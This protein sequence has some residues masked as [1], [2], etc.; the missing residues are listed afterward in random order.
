M[1]QPLAMDFEALARH[2]VSRDVH[3]LGGL[4]WGAARRLV[5]AM[6]RLSTRF[7]PPHPSFSPSVREEHWGPWMRERQMLILLDAPIAASYAGTG[8]LAHLLWIAEEK[9][10]LVKVLTFADAACAGATPVRIVDADTGK[11]LD[12]TMDELPQALNLEM[13]EQGAPPRRSWRLSVSLDNWSRRRWRRTVEE[14]NRSQT[15]ASQR[16]LSVLAEAVFEHLHSFDLLVTAEPGLLTR[17]WIGN[18]PVGFVA[19]EEAEAMLAT[20]L[21]TCDRVPVRFFGGTITQTF[22]QYAGATAA[23]MMAN[24]HR[25]QISCLAPDRRDDHLPVAELLEALIARQSDLVRATQYLE[26]MNYLEGYFGG[27]FTLMSD[28]F[29][30]L[31]NAL[32]LASG[33][34]DMLAGLMARLGEADLP[35]RKVSWGTLLDA[36]SELGRHLKQHPVL[37]PLATR[38]RNHRHRA[39]ISLTHELRSVYQHRHPLRG[40]LGAIRSE[41]GHMYYKS[42]VCL[43]QHMD[44]DVWV[45][46]FRAQSH[47]LPGMLPTDYDL[48]LIPHQFVRGVAVAVAELLDQTIGQLE[49]PNSDWVQP[50]ESIRAVSQERMA[51]AWP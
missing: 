34:V 41:S 26:E 13:R 4:S 1:V 35:P 50:S 45:R 15:T 16:R 49:W 12:L 42:L 19:P 27:T 18:R 14:P 24:V 44:Y 22:H 3:D 2:G 5:G 47:T 51:R 39:L 29:Y 23:A 8:P 21:R 25:A 38:V 7:M 6:P 37:G 36:R 30:H 10:D 11:T 31:Q 32:V 9:P 48:Y 43:A 46:K 20:L 33:S 17:R 28:Q 40:C